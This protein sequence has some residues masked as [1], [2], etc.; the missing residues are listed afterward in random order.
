[1][2]GRCRLDLSSSGQKNVTGTYEQGN[3]ILVLYNPGNFLSNSGI[4]S[5]SRRTLFHELVG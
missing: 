4:I 5:F 2:M 1:M 3:D